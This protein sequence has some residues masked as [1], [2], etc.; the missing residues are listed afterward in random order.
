MAPEEVTVDLTKPVTAWISQRT[1]EKWLRDAQ[2]EGASGEEIRN[3]LDAAEEPEA[4]DIW[5]ALSDSVRRVA[6]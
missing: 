3:Q 5:H 1:A 4:G 6:P 2:S